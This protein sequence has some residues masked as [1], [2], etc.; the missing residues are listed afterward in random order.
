MDTFYGHALAGP[1][2]PRR[3]HDFR[4]ASQIYGQHCV[5]LNLRGE[6]FA[7][8]PLGT[9][10]EDLNQALA[11]QPDGRGFYVVDAAL[12][13]AESRPGRRRTRVIIEWAREQGAPV[14]EG[15]TLAE[16]AEGLAAYGVPPDV[17]RRTLEQT[18]EATAAG[19]GGRL[20]PPRSS[21]A[22]PLATPPFYAVGVQ[23][24]ITFTMGG[25]A[26]DDG[27]RVLARSASSSP[28]AQSITDARDF[29]EVA[30][31]RLFAA[32]CDIGNV[33]HRGYVGGLSVA[34]TTGRTAGLGAVGD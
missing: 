11:R 33:S 15:A 21:D 6:R 17:A 1:P 12:A 8:E 23:A 34:L 26:V 24:A 25:L 27:A 28:M 30:I 32:G 22:A 18:A 19:E 10:E 9:G 29:R 4:E 2:A 16:L 20:S 31:P 3:E 13:D 7:D 5:A 14:A